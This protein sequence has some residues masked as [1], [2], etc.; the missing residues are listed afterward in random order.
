MENKLQELTQRIYTEGVTRAQQEADLIV[1]KAKKEASQ[2]V[3]QAKMEAKEIKAQAEHAA[4]ELKQNVDRE[5]QMSARQ[6][7]TTI[8]QQVASLITTQSVEGV[9]TSLD[10]KAFLSKIIAIAIQNWNPDNQKI[11]LQV[12][13]PAAQQTE[14]EEYF[15]QKQ[16]QLLNA[17][18]TLN[19]DSR[20]ENGFKIGPKDNSYM[21]SFTEEDFTNFFKAYLRPR[22]NE[23]LYGGSK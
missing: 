4:E 2:L 18:L 12:L 3:E 6:A 15:V 10:D 9:K 17:G 7:I 22:T 14:L 21:I 8:R 1:E 13:L 16:Q 19:F 23:L 11:D 5:L 20:M